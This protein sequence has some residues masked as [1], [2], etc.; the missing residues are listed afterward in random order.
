[1]PPW[2]LWTILA[3]LSWGVWAILSKLIGDAL[4]AA[5]SQALSTLGL[6]PVA[7]AL[8]LSGR[9]STTG[10]RRRGVLFALTA[11]ALACAGN[12]AYYRAL[13]VGEKAATVVALTGLYPLVTVVLAMILLRE[14]L[15][16]VQT[17]GIVLSLG[18][19]YLFNVQTES[20]LLSRWLL[21]ALL[22]IAFWGMAGL[23]QKLST[24]HISGELST[25]WFL[26]AFVPAALVILLQQ[27]V[28]ARISAG[29]WLLVAALGFTFG[30]GNLG[31]LAAFARNGK[32]SV[33]TPLSGLYPL[34]SIR[35]RYW[36]WAN[37]LV[38]GKE[39]DSPALG[40]VAGLSWKR[41][42]AP[43]WCQVIIHEIPAG[44]NT[45]ADEV[46]LPP[47]QKLGTGGPLSTQQEST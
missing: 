39:W 20:G 14:R 25:L 13:Q 45:R 29:T 5:Q 32:A 1:M 33:I 3:M 27:E 30:L 9:L 34:V 43:R 47:N 35:L 17:S 36:R 28:P 31:I 12:V 23:L 37:A 4:S 6:V 38:G 41:Q 22:P 19:I 8:L 7:A 2:L 46:V 40:A 18:A 11:G 44:F 21:F 15:N 10:N 42:A 16:R 26:S 24:N